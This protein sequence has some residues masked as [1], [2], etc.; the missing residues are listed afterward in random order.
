M[1]KTHSEETKALIQLIIAM[2]IWGSIGIFRRYIPLSSSL[3]A[4]TRGIIGTLFLILM[5][6][7]KKEK[8]NLAA[9]KKNMLLLILS[10]AFIGF[11][12]ILLFESYNY[13]SV[14][15]ATLC[16]Y[17]APIIVIVV[18]PF[19][20][21]EPLTKKKVF[22]VITALTGMVFVSGVLQTG[23]SNVS[24]F[25]GIFFGLAAAV[26]YGSVVLL[27]K[28]ITDISAYDKTIVQLGSAAIVL[29][30]YTLLTEDLSKI[31][32]TTNTLGFLLLVGVVHTGIAYAL[33]FGSLPKLKAQTAALF[34]Y[35]DP[36]IAILLSAVLLKENIGL[37]GYLGA[38]LVL[39]ATIISE[40]PEKKNKKGESSHVESC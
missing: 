14:A 32:F 37:S 2:A 28:K 15:T 13:T 3:L 21:K 34:S 35:L 40:L 33:Y 6:S 26:L 11:N 25:T 20:L 27:N 1:K 38:V 29:L 39:G 17:M 19:L 12:W 16:Y 36:I 30:P 31:S 7:F 23:I 24:E 22:C 18:S 8:L 10:G 9:I 5:I 4:L